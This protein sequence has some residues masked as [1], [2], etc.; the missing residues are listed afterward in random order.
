MIS[1]R[2]N[3]ASFAKWKYSECHATKHDACI[4]KEKIMNLNGGP[5]ASLRLNWKGKNWRSRT[6]EKKQTLIKFLL[7]I[8]FFLCSWNIPMCF[9]KNFLVHFQRALSSLCHSG[10][11]VTC[12]LQH[13]CF[14]LKKGYKTNN[15]KNLFMVFS[16]YMHHAGL[17]STLHLCKQGIIWGDQLCYT[18][19]KLFWKKKEWY[20]RY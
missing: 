18:G 17:I 6:V 20:W 4:L 11:E 1:L 3:I 5:S 8:L 13:F 7:R 9:W 15:K 10:S 12:F 2:E 16:T 14:A 19:I